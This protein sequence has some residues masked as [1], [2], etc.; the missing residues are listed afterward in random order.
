MTYN[1]S[2]TDNQEEIYDIVNEQDEVIGTATRKEVHSGSK[3]IHRVAG[4]YIFNAKKQLLLQ[5]RSANKDMGAG[6]WAFGVGGH[7]DSGDTYEQAIDREISEELGLHFP[8]IPLGKRL[9]EHEHER[10]YVM[11]FM[12]VHDGP[13]P[14]FN[15]TEAD[16]VSFFDVDYLLSEACDLPRLPHVIVDMPSVKKLVESGRIEELIAQANHS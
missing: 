13:F 7:V 10:E 3:S 14:N 8:V 12:G 15:R 9:V 2:T 11:T 6:F 4:A 1:P 16:E 5:K